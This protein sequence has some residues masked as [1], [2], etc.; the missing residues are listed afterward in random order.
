MRTFGWTLLALASAAL[1]GLGFYEL[2]YGAPY[3]AVLW[4]IV[5]GAMLL[6][7]LWALVT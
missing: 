7:V 1:F 3:V 2:L 4:F 5:A 6:A